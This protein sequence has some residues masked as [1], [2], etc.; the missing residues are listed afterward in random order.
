[1][2]TFLAQL[3]GGLLLLLSLALY[4]PSWTSPPSLRTI[5]ALFTLGPGIAYLIYY[6]LLNITGGIAT[7]LVTYI[8][9]L[10]SYFG[11]GL[12]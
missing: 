6:R 2:I 3:S 12:S 7:S 8:V 4:E 10:F 5:A 1:M 11:A 9:P